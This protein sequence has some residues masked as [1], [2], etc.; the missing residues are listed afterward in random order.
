MAKMFSHGMVAQLEDDIHNFVARLCDKL[1]LEAGR[2]PID[3]TVAYSCF[4]SDVIFD[5]CFG[6]SNGFLNQD[7]WYPNFREPTLAMLKHTYLFKFYPFLVGL[8]AV[9]VWY[10]QPFS[11]HFWEQTPPSPRVETACQ[12]LFCSGGHFF[13]CQEDA[14]RG[15]RELPDGLT[16]HRFLEYLP[17]DIAF[18]IRSLKVTIPQRAVETKEKLDAGF[19]FERPTIFETLLDSDLEG[20]ERRPERLGDEAITVVAAGTETTSWTLAVITF[21]LLDQPELLRKLVQE[22]KAHVE[23]PKDLPRWTVLEKLPY[24]NAVIQEGLRLSYGVSGPM[25]LEAPDEDLIY[26]GEFEKKDVKLL[27]PKGTAM[28]MSNVIT[29]HNEQIFPD[30]HAFVPERWLDQDSTSR[31]SLERAMNTF[32]RGPRACM[33]KK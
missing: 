9:A 28:A 5:Y 24:L 3:I 14:T 2:G 11:S 8:Q 4:T 30:S 33:G 27:I 22:L 16:A 23:D 12:N 20:D 13:E 15:K 6:E 1:L 19:R 18:V 31:K 10:V 7:G 26:R 32:S 29:H 25:A 21:H 17:K